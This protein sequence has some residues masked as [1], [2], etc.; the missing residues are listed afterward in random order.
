MR[1]FNVILWHNIIDPLTHSFLSI[2]WTGIYATRKMYLFVP[3]RLTYEEA[4]QDCLA[5]DAFLADALTEIEYDFLV[6]HM[7]TE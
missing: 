3:E 6:S 4:K 2:E 1:V 7:P 5:R